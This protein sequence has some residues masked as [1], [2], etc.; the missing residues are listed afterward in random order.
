MEFLIDLY[1]KMIKDYGVMFRTG[2]KI[3]M[4]RNRKNIITDLI[5]GKNWHIKQHQ[6]RFQSL[7][8]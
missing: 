6:S 2:Q 7:P 3:F 4:T 1:R 5:L 8:L